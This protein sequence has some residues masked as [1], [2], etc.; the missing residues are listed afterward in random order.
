M[1]HASICSKRQVTELSQ[2][3]SECMVLTQSV[4]GRNNTTSRKWSLKK[5]GE[6][7]LAG[8]AQSAAVC[9]L[10]DVRRA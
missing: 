7:M 2:Q 8:D 6:D 5:V 4:D 1:R 10:C 9:H 3:Y